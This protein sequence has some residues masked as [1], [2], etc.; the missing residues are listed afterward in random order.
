MREARDELWTWTTTT[1]PQS[2]SSSACRREAGEGKAK[3][4][5]LLCGVNTGRSDGC[6][7]SSPTCLRVF[8]RASSEN[9]LSP[10]IYSESLYNTPPVLTSTKSSPLH[11]SPLFPWTWPLDSGTHL[12][13]GV[14]TG[15]VNFP[16]FGVSFTAITPWRT[17]TQIIQL[18]ARTRNVII[19][20]KGAETANSV[21]TS[22]WETGCCC[23]GPCVCGRGVQQEASWMTSVYTEVY[24]TKDDCCKLGQCAD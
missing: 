11:L 5:R 14:W 23:T 13:P 19:C 4:R 15:R 3:P 1:R 12:A 6:Y 17:R 9:F 7:K 8:P 16:C 10:L 18:A 21:Q 20:Q 24:G 22:S 2:P